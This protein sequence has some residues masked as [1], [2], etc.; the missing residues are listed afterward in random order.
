MLFGMNEVSN[1]LK[2]RLKNSA[3]IIHWPPILKVRQG[4]NR[5]ANIRIEGMKVEAAPVVHG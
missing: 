3:T 5:G 2:A 1:A 4:L